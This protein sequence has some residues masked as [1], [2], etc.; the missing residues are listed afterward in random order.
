MIQGE[1]VTVPLKKRGKRY[2]EDTNVLDG[3]KARLRYLRDKFDKLVVAFSGG[4]DSWAL[5]TLLEEVNREDG[6]TDPITVAFR[7]EEVINTTVVDFVTKVAESGKYDFLW[8]AYPMN[9]GMN[10]MGQYKPFVAWDP[11]RKWHRQPPSYAIKSLGVPTAEMDEFQVHSA[12]E[13]F[14]NAIGSCC[15]LM[16][17][18]AAESLKRFM[19]LTHKVKD[20]Y[21]SM[22]TGPK[23]GP[24]TASPLYDWEE[25]DVFKWFYDSGVS[26]CPIYDSQMWVNTSLRVSSSL[27][28]RSLEQL[29]KLK[30]AEPAYW[31]QLVSVLPEL[32]T[33]VRY[34]DEMD[35]WATIRSYP[36]T[37]EGLRQYINDHLTGDFVPMAHAYVDQ[38]ISLRSRLGRK[39]LGGVPMRGIFNDI[40]RGKYWGGVVTFKEPNHDDYV[41]EQQDGADTVR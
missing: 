12:E 20:N 19:G 41:F 25:N 21:I 23:A 1:V 17:I 39:P 10:I 6:I 3:A 38:A 26:Y 37:W 9:V 36:H 22:R 2:I 40:V 27:H 18:R 28:D 5:L 31:A 35:W 32:E 15:V 11:N 8:F 29:V 14:Y 34:S 13:P 7:D 33:Q 30:E 16:G 24:S 4:K